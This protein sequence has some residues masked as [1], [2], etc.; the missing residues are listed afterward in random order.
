MSACLG[1]PAGLVP[2]DIRIQQ[3]EHDAEVAA[4]QSGVPALQCVDVC[5]AHA[6]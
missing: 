2:L 6:S 3:V 5:L 4:V 1:A